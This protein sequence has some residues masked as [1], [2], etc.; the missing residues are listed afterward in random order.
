M[1]ITEQ[2][3]NDGNSFYHDYAFWHKGKVVARC[4]ESDYHETVAE[5]AEQGYIIR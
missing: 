1:I 4:D 5:L 2:N 3:C